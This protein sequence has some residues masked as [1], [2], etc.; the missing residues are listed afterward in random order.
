MNMSS[1]SVVIANPPRYDWGSRPETDPPPLS[2]DEW[3]EL[4]QRGEKLL[5]IMMGPTETATQSEFTN[6]PDE[7]YR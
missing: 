1:H 5:R 7:Y 3:N 2:N 6:F 4:V